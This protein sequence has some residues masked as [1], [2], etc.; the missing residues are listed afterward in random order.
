[1]SEVFATIE[2]AIE[3]IRLGRILI[4]TDDENR[5]NEG[6]FIMAADKVTAQAINFMVIHGRGLLCQSVT[7]RRARELELFPMV[8]KNTSSNITAFTVSVDARENTTTGISAKD[9]EIT[10]KTIVD[11]DA[12]PQDLLRPGHIFPLV[13]KRNGVLTREGHTEAATDLARLAGCTPSG[14]LIEIMD[15]DGTMAKLPRLQ[16]LAKEFNLKIISVESLVKWRKKYDPDPPGY[17]ASGAVLPGIKRLVEGTLPA[18]DGDFRLILYENPLNPNQ[19]HLA[20]VSSK[21]FNPNDA[22]VRIHSE[23]FTGEVLSSTRCD[24]KFQLAEATRRIAE[25][26][27]AVIYLRQE[28]RGIG[29]VEKIKAYNLQD[30][31]YDTVDANLK[32]GH[33]PDER[34]YGIAAAIMKDLG[35]KGF[36]LMTNNPEKE[37]YLKDAGFK[38]NGREKIEMPPGE[39]NRDYLSA[40]KVRFGHHLEYV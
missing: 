4:V 16:E 21:T 22:L 17:E 24:C 23:C 13:S 40:K 10:I 25:E 29:L 39:K 26:G 34:D 9:R 3:E 36:R 11:P 20:M 32:L 7:A 15:T 8:Q 1:M 28:G 37:N 18:N 2:E 30:Q 35:I 33:S 38:I 31:G 19:P 6:D 5:E 12:R 14:V 27:G